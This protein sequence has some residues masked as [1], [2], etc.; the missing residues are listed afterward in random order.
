MA[1]VT[2]GT[3]PAVSF[4]K[5]RGID[6]E[7]PNYTDVLTGENHVAALVMAIKNSAL[8][9]D[10][11]IIITYDE[12]GGFWDHVGPPTADKWGPGS[13]VPAIVISPYA[14][15]GYVDKTVYE[16]TSILASCRSWALDALPGVTSRQTAGVGDL[17]NAFDFS[18]T[19]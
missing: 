8:W 5:P 6:N 7:H 15:K 19:P 14:R 18:Q 16:T 12:N 3:L 10:T 1:G 17:S 13:R 2:A 11:A 4:V 9:K